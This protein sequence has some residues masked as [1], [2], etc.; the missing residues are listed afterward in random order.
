MVKFE[1]GYAGKTLQI[2]VYAENIVRIRISDSFEPTFFEKYRIYKPAE[3]TGTLSE[4]GVTTG[5]LTVKFEDGAIKFSS[6]KFSREIK[7]EN[8]ELS[9]IKSYMNERLNGF[10]DE[11]VVI[12]G[13]EDEEQLEAKTVDFQTD[14]KYITVKTEKVPH[15]VHV[16]EL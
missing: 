5:K 14:P 15:Q 10:H 1:T 3:E 7:L 13:S 12:I 4:N 11:K 6:D 9:E 16:H 8:S 2:S